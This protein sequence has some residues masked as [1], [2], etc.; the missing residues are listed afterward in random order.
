MGI[1]E[2]GIGL[3]IFDLDGVLLD[4][5]EIHYEALNRALAGISRDYVITREEH[6]SRY[7]GLPTSKKLKMLTEEKGLP[8]ERHAEVWRRKQDETLRVM[9]ERIRP[10]ERLRGILGRLRAEGYTLAC[11][12]NSV[13]RT[14]YVAVSQ[15]GIAEYFELLLSNQD[16]ERPKPATEM[17]L[18]C[19][20][21]LGFS[22]KETLIV[23]DSH[24]GRKCAEDAGAWLCA[25]EN[26]GAVNYPRIKRRIKE[27]ELRMDRNS[28]KVKWQ[29]GNMNVLIPLAGE[30]RRFAEAGYSFPKPLIDV[31][32]KPMIQWVVENLNIEARHIFVCRRKHLERYN[33]AHLLRLI[34]PGC[35]IVETVGVT[36][37]A[38]C[39]TLL[40]KHL[41]DNG[42]HLLIANSDQFVADYNSNE[43]MYS[44]VSDEIDGGILTFT[45]THPKWSFVRLGEDGLVKEV[46]EK[47]PISDIATVGIYYW[48]RGSDYVK[49][50]EQMIA[51]N[52]RV[53]N[54][55]YTAPVFNEAIGE[56]K[57]I[58]IFPVQEMWGMGTPEDLEGFVRRVEDLKN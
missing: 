10:D 41:I 25:V 33:L 58:K 12:S 11:C 43:F 37:G 24:L 51:K 38:A 23:E 1:D 22:P 15:L 57:K 19:M 39:T 3:I 17:F 54:E 30:G 47:R 9:A 44:M 27:A 7:D 20:G 16:V 35:E 52:I 8:A 53:N 36:E 50:A 31:K 21:Q 29:G 2:M 18:R 55:F 6:L 49:Y 42:E 32:G 46:A 14:V 28:G 5:R 34:A 56:G 26:P 48:A 4:A 45:A 13:R 40:A